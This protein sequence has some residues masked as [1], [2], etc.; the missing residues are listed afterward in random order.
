MT[1][2]FRADY[3]DRAYERFCAKRDRETQSKRGGRANG[4]P[5]KQNQ[6]QS[7]THTDSGSQEL[8]DAAFF[9]KYKLARFRLRSIVDDD[10][11]GDAAAELFSII[12]S[13][14]KPLSRG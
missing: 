10:D 13:R 6:H 14:A 5:P 1:R 3:G 2:T 11:L 8:S 7:N 12:V 9:T 4:H